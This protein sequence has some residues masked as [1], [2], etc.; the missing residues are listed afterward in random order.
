MIS[1]QYIA[2]FFDGEGSIGVYRNGR[3]NFHLRTQLTQNVLPSSEALLSGL[4][5]RF[6]GN[7]ARMRS[8]IYRRGE[9]F[10]WQLN[11]TVAAQFLR[12]IRPYLVLKAEQADVAMAWQEAKPAPQRDARGRMVGA[13]REHPIDLEAERL[14][15]ALKSFSAAEV[16]AA[17]AD[18]VEIV[19]TLKQVVCVKG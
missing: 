8:S 10:N 19:H 2:G 12:T 6:G 16:M 1:D 11:G 13:R 3:G 15:K 17:Q 5:E 9:A 18:H 7:L 14:L 4:K